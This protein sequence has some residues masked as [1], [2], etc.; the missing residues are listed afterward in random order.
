MAKRR[1]N[2]EGSISKR[3]DGRYMGQVSIPNPITGKSKRETFYGKTQKE[4]LEKINEIKYQVQTGTFT[5]ENDITVGNWILTWLREY[6][7]NR[8]K[9]G[10][11]TNYTNYVNSH[12]IPYLGNIKLQELRADQIQGF[13]NHLLKEGRKK[14]SA[15]KESG[16]SPT[17]I[18]RI[19]I[20]INSALKQALKNGIINKNPASAVTI[21]KQLK[22][23][24]QPLS[25]EEIQLFLETAKEDRLY[26]AF[27]LE[28]GTGLRRGELLGLKWQD[29]DLE[30]KILQVNRSLVVQYDV[31]AKDKGK[32]ATY[33]EFETPKTEKSK[34]VISIPDN[35]VAE[36]KT[37]R[38]RQ[39][40][41][42]LRIGKYYTDEDL[43]FCNIDGSRLHPVSFVSYF[44][45]LLKKAGVRD[46]RFHDLRHSVA[47]L[48]LEMNE[49]PKV[50]Q[51]LLGH[52][53]ITTTL[54]IYSHV[55]LEKKE[56]AAAKLNTIFK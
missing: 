5:A 54:D 30:N 41:E 19:H 22:H 1:S 34:R 8:I 56:Q 13:Y 4:V 52:S 33:L 15:N 10:T 31:N 28:C 26:A 23:E 46:V 45:N 44:K 47:T 38:I 17:T 50:V 21:P 51:E 14:P 35:V 3:L 12:I 42:K 9:K 43:V 32:K 27:I 6:K 29:I 7:D 16:L 18:K 24:I 37:H 11:L 49:H 2:G 39:K 40:E 55:N 20:I 36:L 25:R 53:T 48:L